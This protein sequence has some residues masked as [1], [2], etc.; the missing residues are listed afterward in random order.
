MEFASIFTQIICSIVENKSNSEEIKA[1][2]IFSGSI[3]IYTIVIPTIL[4]FVCW[5]LD[6]EGMSYLAI[7]DLIT[8]SYT[9]LVPVMVIYPI[10]NI[11]SMTFG[12]LK[13][14]MIVVFSVCAAWSELF[15]V[16][17]GFKYVKSFSGTKCQILAI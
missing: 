5:C 9:I 15:V 8:Y 17:H 12:W 3:I 1:I 11:F 13:T 6:M 14:V 10:F 4:F 16:Y 7:L 2:G